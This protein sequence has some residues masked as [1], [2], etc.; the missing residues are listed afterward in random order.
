MTV[1]LLSRAKML[2]KGLE[3]AE[4]SITVGQKRLEIIYSPFLRHKNL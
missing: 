4:M 2:G 1:L 3:M